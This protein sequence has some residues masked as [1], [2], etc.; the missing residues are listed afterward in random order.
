M[1]LRA[2]LS[3]KASSTRRGSL[4]A[5]I[6]A[7][8]TKDDRILRADVAVTWI[9]TAAATIAIRITP[10]DPSLSQPFDMILDVTDALVRIQAGD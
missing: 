9:S 5:R 7:E 4:G 8:L 10:V 1:D 6:S 2:E 3:V